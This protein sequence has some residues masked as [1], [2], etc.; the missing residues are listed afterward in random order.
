M[1]DNSVILYKTEPP[2]KNYW[3]TTASLDEGNNISIVSGDAHAEW[4]INIKSSNTDHLCSALANLSKP[5]GKEDGFNVLTMLKDSFGSQA[6][7]PFEEIREFLDRSNI[8]YKLDR[9]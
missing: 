2:G 9:W 7:N 6:E 1:A 8:P 4:H 3:L 5:Q